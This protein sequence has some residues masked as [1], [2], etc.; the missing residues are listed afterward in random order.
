MLFGTRGRAAVVGH[1]GAPREA[2]ENTLAS[3]RRAFEIGADAIEL[4]VRLSRDGMPIVMH[5]ATLDRTTNGKGPVSAL[6][7]P[8]Q[9]K[10]DAGSWFDPKF[11]GERIPTLDEALA[12]VAGQPQRSGIRVLIEMKSDSQHAPGLVEAVV[13]A[14]RDTRTMRHAIVISF[15]RGAVQRVRELAP[16]VTTG[17]LFATLPADAV[18]VA[19]SAHAQAVLPRWT[20]ADVALVEEAH[21]AGLAIVPWTVDAPAGMRRLIGLGVDGIVTNRPDV[22]RKLV[23]G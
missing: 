5:D 15:D 1:R 17:A 9:R 16:R 19:R 22:L 12:V 11:A 14:V 3:F 13:E 8:E 21:R 10:L 18:T 2:P 7:L 20:V 4:D 23:R 6:T